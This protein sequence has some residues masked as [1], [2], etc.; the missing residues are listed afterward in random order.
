M[1]INARSDPVTNSNKSCVPKGKPT[2][3]ITQGIGIGHIILQFVITNRCP[4]CQSV[5]ISFMFLRSQEGVSLTHLFSAHG[6][7]YLFWAWKRGQ[8]S[9]DHFR[10]VA[11]ALEPETVCEHEEQLG[12]GCGLEAFWMTYEGV[13]W[14]I[15]N[16]CNVKEQDVYSS[17]GKPQAFKM[18]RNPKKTRNT[19]L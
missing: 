5:S 4:L 2:T 12:L 3:K 13:I 16:H 7:S 9:P 10:K 6:N 17:H 1:H 8:G 11:F 19:S 18:Q 15:W 14:L